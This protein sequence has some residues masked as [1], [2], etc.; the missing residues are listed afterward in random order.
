MV[1]VLKSLKLR[2]KQVIE[3]H[4]LPPK[5]TGLT[6]HE[7][8]DVADVHRVVAGSPKP[9]EEV[10]GLYGETKYIHPEGKLGTHGTTQF[11]FTDGKML[12]E[13]MQTSPRQHLR[14][15]ED[16]WKKLEARL[17][18]LKEGTKTIVLMDG[19]EIP[20]EHRGK[21]IATELIRSCVEI[22]GKHEAVAVASLVQEPKLIRLFEREG[23]IKVFTDSEKLP[24]V[25]FLKYLR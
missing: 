1:P 15:V 24:E 20:R 21:G 22:A 23:W 8:F 9:W 4:H 17:K 2:N 14:I 10:K 25:L 5:E 11:A 13:R 12:L 16:E 6:E 18:N 19:T 3:L 7:D